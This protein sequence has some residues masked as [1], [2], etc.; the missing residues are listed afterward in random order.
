[1]KKHAK[2][3]RAHCPKCGAEHTKIHYDDYDMDD[4]SVVQ[5]AHCLA[6]GQHW[7]EVYELDRYECYDASGQGDAITVVDV[8]R[9]E[10]R[11]S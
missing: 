3:K 1:M 4:G 9:L 7:Y 6:C 5:P 8:A 2:F 11:R 10:G